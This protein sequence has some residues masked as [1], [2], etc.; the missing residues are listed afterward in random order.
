MGPSDGEVT[1]QPPAIQTGSTGGSVDV[2]RWAEEHS[3]SVC[4]CLFM[5]EIVFTGR[6]FIQTCI[7]FIIPRQTQKRHSSITFLFCSK[8]LGVLTVRPPWR[9]CIYPDLYAKSYLYPTQ[10]SAAISVR[11]PFHLVWILEARGRECDLQRDSSVCVCGRRD[12]Q[13]WMRGVR[14][15]GDKEE[16]APLCSC[17]PTWASAGTLSLLV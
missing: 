8:P 4:V 14:V 12:Q 6:V 7:F 2:I 3:A 15:G 11:F 16:S 17:G 10:P 5:H 1:S 9:P 13:N